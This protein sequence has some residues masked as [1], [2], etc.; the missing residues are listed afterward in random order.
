MTE[1]LRVARVFPRR[2]S[3]T[4]DDDDAFVGKPPLWV[5]RG[6]YDKV[7]ISVTF[8]WDRCETDRLYQ[9][10][11]PI[12]AVQIGGPAY[13]S[14]ADGFTPGMYLRKG[15]TITSRGCNNMCWYCQVPEREGRLRELP[16]VPGNIVQDNNLPACSP[17][18]LE[19]AFAMLQTQHRIEFPGGR[20]GSRR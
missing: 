18:H 5:K 11:R 19:R 20:Q 1:H 10:W 12:A 9:A 14:P 7:H 2:T 13:T 3:M 4:P 15:V 16:V 6:M 8:T 17:E